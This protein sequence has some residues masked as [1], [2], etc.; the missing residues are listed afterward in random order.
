MN[1]RIRSC[2]T[3]HYF[4]S[5]KLAVMVALKRSQAT[6]ER[7]K[8]YRCPACDGWHLTKVKM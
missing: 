3:K 7:I 6:G 5:K 2:L 4:A 8:V 1:A